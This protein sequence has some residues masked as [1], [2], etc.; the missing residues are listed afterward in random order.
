MRIILYFC[1]VKIIEDYKKTIKSSETEDWLDYRFVR[2][3]SYL[4]ALL[5]ARFDIHPNTVTI[6]SMIIGAASCVFF[7]HGSYFY[8]GWNGLFLNLIAIMMLV[9]ADVFDCTDGQLARLTGKRS[10]LGR[11]LDGAAGFVWFIPI[12]LAIDYRFYIHHDIEFSWLGLSGDNPSTVMIATA[13]VFVLSLFSGFMG[14]SS[15]QRMAD[16]Y[17]QVHLFFLKGEKGAELDSS[18]QQQ[19]VFDETPWEG[20][21]L[22]K[23]F[24]RSYISYTQKQEAA[25]PKFQQ[26]MQVLNEKYGSPENMPLEIRERMLQLSRQLMPWNAMLTFNFRTIWL[27]L[28]CLSDIPACYFLFEVI[29][30]E[31]LTRGII[32]YHESECEKIIPL[33]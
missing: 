17:I 30:M 29:V 27:I 6:I 22:W 32:R 33:T 18:A 13:V 19:K 9:M 28:F 4:W 2:P 15:Q 7:A 5:F 12:Y 14:I 25:T 3:F 31:L 10:Q 8:E 21:Y 20:N 11:I 1:L 24:L 16:Y 26:L 23:T